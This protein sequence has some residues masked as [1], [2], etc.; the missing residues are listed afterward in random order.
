MRDKI[1]IWPANIDSQK[2]RSDGRKISEKDAVPSPTLEEIE[3]AA[4]RLGLNPVVEKDKAYPK[5]WWEV[6]GRVIADKKKPKSILLKEIAA[7]IKK[8]RK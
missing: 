5:E 2:S 6:S 7:E 8:V 1:I 4:E 3:E